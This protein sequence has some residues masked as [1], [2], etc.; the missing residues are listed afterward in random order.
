MDTPVLNDEK[1]GSWAREGT[2]SIQNSFPHPISFHG[3]GGEEVIST[4]NSD[5]FN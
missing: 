3:R 5:E 1:V 4:A 2:Y